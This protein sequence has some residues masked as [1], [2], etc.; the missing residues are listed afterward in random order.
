MLHQKHVFGALWQVLITIQL[1]LLRIVELYAYI[2]IYKIVIIY[3]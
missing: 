2:Y 1:S 3:L